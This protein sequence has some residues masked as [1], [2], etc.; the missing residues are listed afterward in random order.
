MSFER[1]YTA[2]AQFGCYQPAIDD[3][4]GQLGA[5]FP[6]A[7]AHLYHYEGG[8]VHDPDDKGGETYRGI[9]RKAWPSW[10]GWARVDILKGGRSV[11][12]ETKKKIND[13]ELL[14]S[15]TKEFFRV[16]YWDK[17]A[18]G[19]IAD[20][21]LAHITWDW[22]VATNSKLMA[23]YAWTALG[24]SG[25]VPEAK[26]V[27]VEMSNA[28]DPK[29]VFERFKKLREAHH[30]NKVAKQPSQEKF[31]KGWLR[32]NDSFVYAGSDLTSGSSIGWWIGGGLLAF[33][34]Y[35]TIQYLLK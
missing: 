34:G 18:F 20:Q 29:R 10:K 2:T 11:T 14:K 15:W 4:D 33:G 24:R 13:D 3:L 17:Y 26:Q 19:L 35:K 7:Y 12:A 25:N 5:A 27:V 1:I 28:K 22:T 23:S 32:R 30:K 9:A 6:P 8:W 16:N 31:L 21:S